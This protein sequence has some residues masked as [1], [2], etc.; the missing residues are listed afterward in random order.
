[1]ITYHTWAR[2]W[3]IVGCCLWG[4]NV[5][6]VLDRTL[7]MITSALT[8]S[9][10]S[11]DRMGAN[12]SSLLLFIGFNFSY[13]NYSCKILDLAGTF[14][15]HVWRSPYLYHPINQAEPSRDMS[16]RYLSRASSERACSSRASDPSAV[17]MVPIGRGGCNFSDQN[18]SCGILVLAGTFIIHLWRPPLGGL[19]LTLRHV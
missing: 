9:S 10:D 1:M 5:W 14:I 19:L 16:K 12:R 3:I 15:I 18:Y 11:L 8:R 13:Q 6:P 7:T 2:F 4:C 17:H